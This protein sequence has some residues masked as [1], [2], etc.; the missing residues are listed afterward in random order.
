M[1][2]HW[3]SFNRWVLAILCAAACVFSACGVQPWMAEYHP[4]SADDAV[5]A[6]TDAYNAKRFD[7]LALLIHPKKRDGFLEKS[8]TIKSELKSWRVDRFKM[9][10]TVEAAPGVQGRVARLGYHDGRRGSNRELVVVEF[11]GQW[12]IWRH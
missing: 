5:R 9:G 7:Q 4:G 8:S 12:W 1:I 11:K 6:W 3:L 10:G 2:I